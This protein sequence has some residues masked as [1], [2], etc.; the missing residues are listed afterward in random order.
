M[1]K[2]L[3]QLN[4]ASVSNAGQVLNGGAR[5]LSAATM[6]GSVLS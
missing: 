4:C 6:S 1:A 5:V 3:L 2:F